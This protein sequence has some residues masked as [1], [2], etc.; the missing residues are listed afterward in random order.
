VDIQVFVHPIDAQAHPSSPGWR[1]AVH[2]HGGPPED[3]NCCANAGW[4][5]DRDGAISEGD[6]QGATAARVLK[7]HG[8]DARYDVPLEL[9]HDPIPAG[10]DFVNVA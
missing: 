10:C 1:W 5:P 3:L 6:R 2:V 4:A 7:M 8:I 9:D